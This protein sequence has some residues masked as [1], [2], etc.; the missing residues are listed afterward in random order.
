[1]SGSRTTNA[2]RV[3]SRKLAASELKGAGFRR[4]GIHLIRQTEEVIQAV[5]L[6]ASRWGSKEKGAFTVNLVITWQS[7][8]E[9]WINEQFPKNP[10]TA[11]FPTP[12]RIGEL[13]PERLDHWWD[14]NGST[15][16]EQLSAD[17]LE[18]LVTLALPFF[19]RLTSKQSYY[20][21]LRSGRS[22]R[23]DFRSKI[24]QAIVAHELGLKQASASI[25][26]DV[27]NESPIEEFQNSVSSLASR[28][29]VRT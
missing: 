11:L 21:E 3:V 25:L 17:V 7:I 26:N 2:I 15:D 1:M 10:A 16:V 6:Q 28:L 29:S 23:P 13:S 20:D 24:A 8:Y 19:D 22:F 14:V 18:V 9:T 12:V 27:I 5:H 4:S